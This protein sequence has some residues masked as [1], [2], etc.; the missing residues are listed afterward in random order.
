[1]VLS[2]Y[3]IVYF[4]FIVVIKLILLVGK[5]SHKTCRYRLNL[6]YYRSEERRVGK[7]C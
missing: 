4:L 1:M 7:E 5:S 2:Y 6:A 3:P